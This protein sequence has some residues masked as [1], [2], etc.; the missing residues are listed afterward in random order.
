MMAQEQGET[1]AFP[2]L[3]ERLR[4]LL[5]REEEAVYLVGGAVRDALLGEPGKDLDF[6]VSRG[7]IELAFRIGDALRAP[8]Y[9]LDRERDI[10][11]VVL[12]DTV[13]DF[14]RFRGGTLRADLHG[15]DFTINAMALPA[16]ARSRAQLID[17]WGGRVDL[18]AGLVRLTY[19]Q[20]LADDPVRALRAVRM[21]AGFDFRLTAETVA[22]V[23]AAGPALYAVSRERVRDEGV[24]LLLLEDAAEAVGNLSDLGLLAYVLPEV[25]ALR[26]VA[27]TPPHHEP[28]LAHTISVLHWLQQVKQMVWGEGGEEGALAQVERVL[29]PYAP[30]LAAHLARAVDGNVDGETLLQLGALF[31]DVGKAETRSVGDDGRVRFLGHDKAGARL[32]GRRLRRLRF[33]NAA[34][35]AVQTIV[36]GHMRPLYLNE[37]DRVT[38]R[39]VYRYFRATGAAGLDIGILSLA[40]HLATHGGPGPGTVWE[41]L[42]SVVQRLYRHYF[43]EYEETV[44]PPPLLD[45]RELIAALQLQPGPE[46]GRLLRLLEEAQAAGEIRTREEA[47]ALVRRRHAEGAGDEGD[48]D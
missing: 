44:A 14:A 7:A 36:A 47:L 48:L 18:E 29:A 23:R 40:D 42:L 10:G 15:R 39:A 5:A 30:A 8:A 6:V 41:G 34:V 2:P 20:A 45:G 12:P 17:P 25:A 46:V 4:P 43:E 37:G 28:V 3:M 32:A 38:R 33:S 35:K 21:A 26:D 24:K 19:P 16:G 22:A 11:R 1:L 13:L 31:H 27:Q 9:T